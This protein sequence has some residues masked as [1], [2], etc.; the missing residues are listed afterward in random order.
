MVRQLR[1]RE[2]GL[3][4]EDIYAFINDVQWAA[5]ES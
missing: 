3:P 1:H 4:L 2:H 5:Y